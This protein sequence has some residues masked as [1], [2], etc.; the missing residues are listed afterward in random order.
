MASNPKRSEWYATPKAKRH[1]KPIV[2]TLGPEAMAA[3]LKLSEMWRCSKSQ[4]VERL[5]MAAPVPNT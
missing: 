2:L 5:I 4:A 1:R 3:L